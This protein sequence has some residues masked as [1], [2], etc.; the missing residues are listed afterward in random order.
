MFIYL[1][2]LCETGQQ[3][4]QSK[5]RR[6]CDLTNTPINDFSELRDPHFSEGAEISRDSWSKVFRKVLLF[7]YH[8]FV[9]NASFPMR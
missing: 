8:E 6:I 3:T 2:R 9:V 1:P 5:L 4:S 7:N